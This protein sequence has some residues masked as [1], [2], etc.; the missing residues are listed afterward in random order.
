[1]DDDGI[2]RATN[3]ANTIRY[4]PSH[5]QEGPLAEP[6]WNCGS[7]GVAGE[8]MGAVCLFMP[9]PIIS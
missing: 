7:T 3:C 8:G 1:M 2:V 4:G 6:V 5:H 9:P